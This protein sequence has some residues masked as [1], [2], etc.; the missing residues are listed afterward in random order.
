MKNN[1]NDVDV[2]LDR[3]TLQNMAVWEP[4]SFRVRIS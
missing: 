4:R 3:K 1:L 2:A